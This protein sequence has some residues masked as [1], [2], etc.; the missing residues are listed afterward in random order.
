MNIGTFTATG[1]NVILGDAINSSL[2]VDNSIQRI[3]KR[4]EDD[5]GEDKEALKG[6]L[7]EAKELIENIQATREIPKNKGF[8]NRLSLHLEKH[9][10]FY[11]EITGL[12]GNAVLT[13]IQG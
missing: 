11:G 2:N 8:F 1:S 7:D 5:G 10:W 3:E 4:I 12:L 13:M 6:L 9:G